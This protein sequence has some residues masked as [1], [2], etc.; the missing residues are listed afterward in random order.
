MENKIRVHIIPE[1]G[2][3]FRPHGSAYIRL[4]RPL[5]HPLLNSKL[6]VTDSVTYDDILEATQIVI[7]DRFWRPDI[8][9]ENAKILVDKIK[10][11]HAKF[12]YAF[13]DDFFAL[14]AV[15]KDFP[16]PRHIEVFEFFLRNADSLLVTT[17]FLKNKYK[18]WNEVVHVLPNFMDERLICG[19]KIQP[20]VNEVVRIGYMGT[21]THKD[22]L[23]MVLPALSNLHQKFG[24]R[25]R[26]ELLGAVT[27]TML[28]MAS[29]DFPI[30]N[31]PTNPENYEYPLFMTWFTST[32]NWDIGI[33]PFKDYEFNKAK[34]YI[35]FLDY[36]A[37]QAAGIF[38]KIEEYQKVIRPGENG[39]LAENLQEWEASF[40]ELVENP[41]LRN[42]I[43]KSVYAELL[44][45]HTIQ[46]NITR[47]YK[48]I[49]DILLS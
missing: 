25:I 34:S 6:M 30:Y 3:D 46:K 40:I 13:D 20:V 16:T 1:Y 24:S 35:K 33:S 11:V 29:I 8:N 42:N 17:D 14:Q 12:V 21:L 49:Q 18:P 31:I 19:M 43:K 5:Y 22:D 27:P 38:S 28:E 32:V 41:V 4:L 10:N 26:F 15:R 7:V 48:T 36:A 9:L 2:I 37:I 44:N 23:E 47:I 45:Q 39:F